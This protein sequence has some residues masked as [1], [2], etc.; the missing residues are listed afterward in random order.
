MTKR[1]EAIEMLKSVSVTVEEPEPVEKALKAISVIPMV[2]YAAAVADD[3]DPVG[4]KRMR[5]D[6]EPPVVPVRRID[7]PAAEVTNAS[8]VFKSCGACGTVH[9]SITTCPRCDYNHSIRGL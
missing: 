1:K 9:K 3:N 4:T 5:P 6:W 7:T 2:R 8:E